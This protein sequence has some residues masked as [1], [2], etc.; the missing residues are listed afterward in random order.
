[1]ENTSIGG[2]KYYIEF[3]DDYSR[4]S[5]VYFLKAKSEVLEKFKEFQR[6]TENQT[7]R[8]IKVLRSDN[9][10]EYMSTLFKRYLSDHGIIHQTTNP[11]TPEQNGRSERLNRTL[12]EKPRCLLFQADLGKRFWAEA[13]NT[14][15][16]L[17]NRSTVAN[18]QTTPY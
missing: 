4:M 6:L 17:R 9:G 13:V 10:G 1:M 7:G 8:K 14:A 3:Q 15:C 2:S 5:F 12:I 18:I 16:Y 11:Y